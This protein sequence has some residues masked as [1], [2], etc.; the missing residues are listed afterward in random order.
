MPGTGGD[1]GREPVAMSSLS[2]DTSPP[3]CRER[4][5]SPGRTAVTRSCSTSMLR[6]A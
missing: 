1:T 4:L 5:L 3:L 6:S 2:Y